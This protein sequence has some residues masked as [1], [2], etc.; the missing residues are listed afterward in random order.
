MSNLV[1]KAKEGGTLFLQGKAVFRI[2]SHVQGTGT[3]EN[4][5]KE[6]GMV[7]TKEEFDKKYANHDY[8][9]ILAVAP[10][11]YKLAYLFGC[12]NFERGTPRREIFTFWYRLLGTREWV[13]W[14]TAEPYMD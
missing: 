10:I 6:Y 12:F 14:F 11:T 13:E 7:T 3:S 2:T 4:N 1:I 8:I 5:K 9:A